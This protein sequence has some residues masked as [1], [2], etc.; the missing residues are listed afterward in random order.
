M[1]KA[2]QNLALGLDPYSPLTDKQ[3][4]ALNKLRITDHS[5]PFEITNRLLILLDVL[6]ERAKRN[7]Q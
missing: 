7:L 1:I 6:E 5:N 3:K 2:I 4:A